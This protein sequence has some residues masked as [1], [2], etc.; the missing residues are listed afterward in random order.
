MMIVTCQ[1][2]SDLDLRVLTGIIWRGPAAAAA[3]S[4]FVGVWTY[5]TF[6]ATSFWFVYFILYQFLPVMIVAW[7]LEVALDW[8][9]S[10]LPAQVGNGANP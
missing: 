4:L 6:R 5:Y 9:L 10:P 2:V 7:L 3:I 8:L 1:W